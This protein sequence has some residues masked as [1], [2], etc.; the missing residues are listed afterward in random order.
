MPAGP[1]IR[2]DTATEPW[3]D[4]RTE[5][6]PLLAKLMVHGEDRPSAVARLRRA[7]DE[8]LIGGVQTDAGF[9]R[10][11]VD[12]EP[13]VTGAYDTGLIADHWGSGPALAPADA[14]LAAAVALE[15]RR[16]RTG[17]WTAA[18]AAASRSAW[19]DQARREALRR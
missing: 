6:D 4:L 5:Y 1:G 18:P 10:W 2:V 3:S 17:A 16:S 11:L 15:A 9:L 14:E 13:F 8:V 19:G 7:L 12:A